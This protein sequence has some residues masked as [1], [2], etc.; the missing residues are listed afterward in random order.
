M[1]PKCL[2]RL[3]EKLKNEDWNINHNLPLNE[4]FK[5]FHNNLIELVDHFLPVTTESSVPRHYEENHG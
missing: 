2:D 1:R 4:N 3:K 5:N